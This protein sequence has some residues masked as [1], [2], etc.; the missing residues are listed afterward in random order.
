MCWVS[1]ASAISQR[2]FS[3]CRLYGTMPSGNSLWVFPQHRH[4]ITLR[5]Y[6]RVWSPCRTLRV[7]VPWTLSGPPQTGQILSSLL[8]ILVLSPLRD[9]SNR[10]MLIMSLVDERTAPIMSM[11]CCNHFIDIM[12]AVFTCIGLKSKRAKPS[13]AWLSYELLF[14]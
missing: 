11:K 12:G 10:A 8:K 13:S 6:W 3:P 14:H 4:S 5:W 9:I 2:E 7:Q 1:V